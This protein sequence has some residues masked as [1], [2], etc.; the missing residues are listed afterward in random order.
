MKSLVWR[1]HKWR[2]HAYV[3][4]KSEAQRVAAVLKSKNRKTHIIDAS[5]DIYEERYAVYWRKK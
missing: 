5:R 4:G 3:F 2:L 1:G